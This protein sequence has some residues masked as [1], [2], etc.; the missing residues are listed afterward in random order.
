M[1]YEN[2]EMHINVTSSIDLLLTKSMPSSSYSS[3]KSQLPSFNPLLI[4]NDF[5][6][7]FR[8]NMPLVRSDQLSSLESMLMND[9]KFRKNMVIL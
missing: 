1:R 4:D 6:A 8:S 2:S 3:L 9:E 7:Y 5:N